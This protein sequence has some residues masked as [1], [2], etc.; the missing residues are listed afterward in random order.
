MKVLFTTLIDHSKITFPQQLCDYSVDQAYHG[1]K[2]LLGDDLEEDWQNPVW[3]KDYPNL[4]ELYGRGFTIYGLID[5]PPQSLE[6]QDKIE[7]KYYD[8]IIVPI[9]NNR[10]R[11][12]KNIEEIKRLSEFSQVKVID[13]NDETWIQEELLP[14]CT[15]FKRELISDKVKPIT[16]S[17][18]E[19][20]I[21]LHIPDK[22]K[23]VSDILPK[24]GGRINWT[25]ER[26]CDYYQEYRQ[27]W[28]AHTCKKGGWD[29]LRHYE[30][31]ANGCIPYFHNIHQC[32]NNTLFF[33][34]K[35]L[36]LEV[37]Q[38]ANDLT[39]LDRA[40]IIN[41]FLRHCRTFLTTEAIAKYILT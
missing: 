12:N 32:P 18:P 11:N 19:E 23:D 1:L 21:V 29:S 33:F 20:K 39:I 10:H 41:E 31:I 16:F 26:E 40:A 13:G 22:S 5:R 34:P 7:N 38:R 14:F 15:Y 4:D 36:C 25:Y 9:H 24:E 30:I 8:Q 17:I 6:I 28:F 2:T 37:L 3:Y 35:E 27:S